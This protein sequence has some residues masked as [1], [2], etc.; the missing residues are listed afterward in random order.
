MTPNASRSTTDDAA[1]PPNGVLPSQEIRRLIEAGGIQATALIGEAQIQPASL[2]LRLGSTAYRVRASFLPGPGATVQEKIDQLGMHRID[3]TR[4]AVLER[5]CVYIVP[6]MESLALPEG[7][8]GLANPK[9]STGRLDIFTRVITD[10]ASEFERVRSG[11]EGPLYM[12]IAPRT[13]SIIVRQGSRL[14]QLRLRRGAPTGSDAALKRLH[15]QVR[16][17]DREPGDAVIDRGLALSVDLRGP[18][19]DQPIGYIARQHTGLVDVDRIGGYDPAEF[20]EPI[21]APGRAG[22]GEGLILN[23]DDFYILASKESV[24]V[25]PDHAA[26]MVAYDTLVGEFRVHYAGFFDPAFGYGPSASGRTRAVLEVRSHEVPFLLEDGQI[27]GRLVYEKLTAVPDK[28]YGSGI[29]SSYQRQ[30]LTLGKQFRQPFFAAQT[31]AGA[32]DPQPAE[33]A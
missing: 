24:T 21:A 28:L 23:P 31:A 7:V 16:L 8:F 26:E 4:D 3:L 15:R 5:G 17:V 30:G 20:W 11:Y 2:D 10:R 32:V 25:P 22:R 33:P 29:G 12:E 9:S 14:G 6:L 27:V 18:G 13:F 1:R 19:G